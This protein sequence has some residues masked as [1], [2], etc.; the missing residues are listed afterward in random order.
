MHTHSVLDFCSLSCVI[1]K[2]RRQ[3]GSHYRH[4]F[5][6]SSTYTRRTNLD[7]HALTMSVNY[8]LHVIAFCVHGCVSES[9]TVCG[10]TISRYKNY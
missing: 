1:Y 10:M 3:T 9:F 4:P 5:V 8:A 6:Y 2:L 7:W